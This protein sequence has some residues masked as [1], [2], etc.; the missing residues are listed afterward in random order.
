M[1]LSKRLLW[2]NGAAIIAIAVHHAAAFSLQAMFDWT[3]RYLAVTVPNYD[4]LGSPAYHILMTLRLL[5][6]FAGPAFF[7]ISGYFVGITAKGSS[8]VSWSMVFSRIKL[9]LLPFLLWTAVRFILL[10]DLP[11]DIDDILTPYHWI[12]L[13]IQFYLVS[14]FIVTLARRSW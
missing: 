2:L 11:E 1:S 3:D 12:P 10:R 9:L 8:T 13:L 14:P 5:L 4:Q 6:T 7:F